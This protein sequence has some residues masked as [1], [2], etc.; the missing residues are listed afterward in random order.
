MPQV[1]HLLGRVLPRRHWLHADLRQWLADTQRR[2]ARATASHAQR[3][4]R[5]L[6]KLSV[7]Y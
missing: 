1:A 7:S 5:L 3:R 2:H 4:L 6:H